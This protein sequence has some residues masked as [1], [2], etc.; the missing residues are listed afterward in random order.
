MQTGYVARYKSLED[1]ICGIELFVDNSKLCADASAKARDIAVNKFDITR[2]V[3]EYHE[4][5]E[6]IT[7]KF[8]EISR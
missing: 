8:F 4:L 3:R 5:Y 2:M 6:E 7:R 1:F